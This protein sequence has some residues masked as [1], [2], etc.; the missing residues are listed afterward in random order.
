MSSSSLDQSQC[1]DQRAGNCGQDLP[2]AGRRRSEVA[3]AYGV[4]LVKDAKYVRVALTGELTRN[5]LENAREETIRA[6]TAN[7]WNRLLVDV[8]R[9]NRKLSVAEDFEFTSEHQSSFPAGVRTALVI[10]PDELEYFRF[11]ENVAQ[12]RGVNMKLFLDK[13]QALNW[14]LDR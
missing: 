11:T 2:H 5:D 3:M 1:V 7:G 13:I 6:L 14:L 9:G 4:E 12:N 8:T 10:R